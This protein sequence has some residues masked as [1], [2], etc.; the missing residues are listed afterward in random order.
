MD[1]KYRLE[2]NAEKESD[3]LLT[4][5]RLVN[6]L[7]GEIEPDVDIAICGREIVGVGSGYRAK[8]VIDVGGR[9][10]YPGFIDAHIHLE[11]TKLTIPEVA[12]L[13]ARFGTSTVIT[14]PHEISNVAALDGLSYQIDSAR[15][16]GYINVFF[17]A[18]SCVPTLTDMSI[19]SAP[20]VLDPDKLRMAMAQKEV[21]G[22]GEVMNVPG[23]LMGDATVL[24]K[25]SDFRSRGLVIDGHA[26]LVSGP[27][28]NTCVYMGV[29]SDHESTNIDE[30]RE[31]LRRGMYIMIREGSSEKNLDALLPL[32]NARN[33]GRMMFASDDLDPTDLKSRGHI[34]HLVKRAVAAGLDPIAAI[35]MATLS[36][37]MYFGLQN[38]LGAIFAGAQADI[39]IAS[40][41][42]SFEPDIVLHEGRIVFENGA[43]QPAGT[44]H[45]VYLHSTMNVV[46]PSL[47]ALAVH[48]ETGQK[49]RAIQLVP[50][51]I[52]TRQ[53][54][55][56]PTIVN[57]MVQ[58]DKSMDIAK[59]C[60]FERHHGSGAFGKAFVRGFGL[61][62]GAIGS[63][64][65]HDSHN[66]V[67]VGM[68]DASILQCARM[69]QKMGGGQ[70]AVLGDESAV[71]PLPVA[72]LMSDRT[73]D[74][75][76]R[77]E[78]ALDAFC[79]QKLGV[80]LARP[81]AALSFMSLPVIPE[82]RITDQGLF[83]IAPGGYPVKVDNIVNW[84]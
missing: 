63:S 56:D 60:V 47:D 24:E 5:C 21:V 48:A 29:Q 81:M 51:Q 22:L 39:V 80:T 12:R 27:A 17:V 10:V 30:A 1:K 23:I 75:V 83:Y 79:A 9:Y 45:K 7:S 25:I 61:Q 33:T 71:L 42:S 40:D 35:Q 28:L 58:A 37:A 53:I 52:L 65:G 62:C 67:V 8:R 74:E 16:N 73:A 68:D 31:K 6:V 55:F 14:D 77:D 76:I 50:G 69:I 78:A 44:P 38:R 59:V 11:S 2:A 84:H 34:N 19:E 70:A 46:L 26:P 54:E 82:L 36:P 57:G 43:I 18:P 49:L 15:H 20:S 66:M 4:H 72:G 3:L 41:L 64:V 13:M 32:V